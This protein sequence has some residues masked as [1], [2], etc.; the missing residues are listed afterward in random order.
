MTLEALILTVFAS[1]TQ[2]WEF[3][4]YSQISGFRFPSESNQNGCWDTFWVWF[5]IFQDPVPPMTVFYP[6]CLHTETHR[7]QNLGEWQGVVP[8]APLSPSWWWLQQDIHAATWAIL[9]HYWGGCWTFH[10]PPLLF[11]EQKGSWTSSCNETISPDVAP[12]GWLGS[13]TP[14]K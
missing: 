4:G 13:K 2:G 10:K 3:S 6:G 8:M 12:S 7:H 9:L 14:T 1:Y 5:F 11:Y